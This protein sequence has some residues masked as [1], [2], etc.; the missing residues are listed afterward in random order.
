MG[1]EAA[2]YEQRK[3]GE[4]YYLTIT[5]N[6]AAAPIT[7]TFKVVG[8]LDRTG[9]QDDGT[10]FMPFLTA[11]RLFNR[12]NE[13]TIVGV[14]LKEF[15]RRAIAD[16]TQRWYKLPE[17]QVVGLEQVKSTLIS[18]VGTAQTMIAAVAIVAVVVAII[19]VINTIL[20]SVYERT[21]E[22]GIMKAIGA[23]RGDIFQLVWIETVA[24]CTLGGIVGCVLA[25]V[26]STVV[27]RGIRMLLDLGIVGS[28]VQIT[29]TIAVVAIVGAIVLGF[30]AGL[31]PAWRAASMRPI[32]AIREGIG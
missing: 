19:G 14:K 2:T 31:Y 11:Q 8:I 24:V 28:L 4:S 23:R 32:D 18:L 6:R 25:V 20:M 15:S 30:F 12:P 7:R 3:V 13:L 9:S 17:V 29:P 16:F 5:P 1:Y 27:D 26:G 21:G 22:I 10:I